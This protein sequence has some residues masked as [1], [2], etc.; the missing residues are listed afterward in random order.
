MA[1][2]SETIRYVIYE[3]IGSRP[4]T[5]GTCQRKDFHLVAK[6]LPHGQDGYRA[7]IMNDRSVVLDLTPYDLLFDD[8]LPDGEA[9]RF[10][11]MAR[12][13]HSSTD[14]VTTV[15]DLDTEDE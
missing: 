2:Q 12:V 11:A 4:V 10:A 5:Q 15:D 7:K 3:I 8:P 13:G 1:D 9:G 6:E 14:G